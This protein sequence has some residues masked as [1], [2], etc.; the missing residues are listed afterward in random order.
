MV[1]FD[2]LVIY[3]LVIYGIFVVEGVLMVVLFMWCFRY[4]VIVGGIVFYVFFVFSFY[5]MYILFIMLVIVLYFLFLSGDVVNWIF[6]FLE[7]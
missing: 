7:M 3:Y 2:F 4:Y 1:W 6:N 5:V